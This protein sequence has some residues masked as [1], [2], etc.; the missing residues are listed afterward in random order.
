[1]GKLEIIGYEPLLD[2]IKTL[3]HEK[4]YQ[5]LSVANEETIKLY[6]KIGEGY[7]I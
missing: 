2:D 4:Q 6:L 1:M 5:I 7:Y 3:I